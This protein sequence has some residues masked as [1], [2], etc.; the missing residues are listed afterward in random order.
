MRTGKR[1]DRLGLALSPVKCFSDETSTEMTFVTPSSPPPPPPSLV[2]LRRKIF[3][4]MTRSS[5][6]QDNGSAGDRSG[7]H[8]VGEESGL[9]QAV[10]P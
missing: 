3:K 9:Y 5:W 4:R 6:P 2:R 1:R 7:G 10:T 8:C